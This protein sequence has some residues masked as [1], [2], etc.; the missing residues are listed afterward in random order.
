MHDLKEL[1]GA[2]IAAMGKTPRIPTQEFTKGKAPVNDQYPVSDRPSN[3]LQ[4]SVTFSKWS[5]IT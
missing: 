4:P 2:A 5:M 3:D 1:P